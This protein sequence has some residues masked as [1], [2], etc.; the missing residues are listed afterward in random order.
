MKIDGVAA[1][2]LEFVHH[3]EAAAV[4]H[5]HVHFELA[6]QL[7]GIDLLVVLRAD[8]HVGRR[9]DVSPLGLAD[10]DKGA[11]AVERGAA[12]VVGMDSASGT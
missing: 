10:A 8:R 1:G 11:H 5:A 7:L 4:D 3:P 12:G 6:R 9:V 2:D